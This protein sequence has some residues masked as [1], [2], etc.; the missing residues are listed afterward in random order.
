M[1]GKNNETGTSHPRSK[2]K[3]RGKKNWQSMGF[4]T[5]LEFRHHLSKESDSE[6]HEELKDDSETKL[7][8][9]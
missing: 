4:K 9:K 2:K 3:S 7:S 6:G 1:I 5:Y 8:K